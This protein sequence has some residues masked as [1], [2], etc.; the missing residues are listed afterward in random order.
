MHLHSAGISG[1]ALHWFASYLTERRQHVIT[2]C[3]SS[4]YLDV[5]RGVSQGSILGPTLFNLAVAT[6]PG[7]VE[8]FK[9]S[10]FLFADD[11]TLFS[12]APSMQEAVSHVSA[13]LSAI[14]SALSDSGLSVNVQKTRLMIVVPSASPEAC[15]PLTLNSTVIA[16]TQSMRC[17]G[18]TVPDDLS[19]SEHVDLIAAKVS[20]KLGAL[21]LTA[22][23]MPL[24]VR[25]MYF[26]SI[27]QPDLEYAIVS[28]ITSTSAADRNRLL[29]L[30]RR[31]IRI[32]AGV[33]PQADVEELYEKLNIVPLDVRW[34]LKLG[35]FAYSCHQPDSP[36]S[37]SNMFTPLSSHYATRASTCGKALVPR[38][39]TMS[40]VN[41]ISTRLSLL[42]NALP[43]AITTKP[44]RKL[45]KSAI[46]Y[47]LSIVSNL[48]QCLH[49]VF[50]RSVSSL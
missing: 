43:T 4:P 3:D 7:L 10:L 44:T 29:A 24:A 15:P 41:A 26:L 22:R 47:H 9:S 19:W 35:L 36:P 6:L 42:W 30:H 18:I 39:N 27:V 16:L 11:K 17:L 37:L 25:R 23:M 40:G 13:A 1:T 32:V 2:Q 49:L 38:S 5:S 31:G 14:A 34:L 28:F 48:A 12:S 20:R 50:D 8:Q 33:H 45:F 46:L 21:R